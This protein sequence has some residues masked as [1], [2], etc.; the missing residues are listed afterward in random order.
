MKL[1][2]G[3]ERATISK[4]DR[5]GFCPTEQKRRTGEQ[6]KSGKNDCPYEVD[7]RNGIQGDSS[8]QPGR[9]ITEFLRDPAV[10]YFV[11]NDG[12]Q[13][14][15]YGENHFLCVNHRSPM[16]HQFLS[17]PI[18]YQKS[19]AKKQE[20]PGARLTVPSP[21]AAR[22]RV[23]N[24]P[25]VGSKRIYQYLFFSSSQIAVFLR[26]VAGRTPLRFST[27]SS[28]LPRKS[29]PGRVPDA[30]IR[31]GETR[32]SGFRPHHRSWRPGVR[33]ATAGKSGREQFPSPSGLCP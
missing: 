2:S 10:S 32:R 8:H 16:L 28:T 31:E 1:V 30:S 6:Q 25:A 13:Q 18:R 7:M 23:R 3:P 11:K 9:G 29:L 26:F 17:T 21:C 24:S 12:E 5:H 19:K 22:R 20:A 14:R 15:Y 27:S 33:R 4:I